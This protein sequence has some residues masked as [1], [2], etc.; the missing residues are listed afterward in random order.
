MASI[1]IRTRA[2]LPASGFI[3]SAILA[4]APALAQAPAD[5]R[6]QMHALMLACRGDYRR[7]CQGVQPG[8][9][10][11]LGC[12]ESHASALTA[13]C[14]AAVPHAEAL[15]QQRPGAAAPQ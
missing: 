12:L 8:G 6:Q 14:S 15:R 7:L 5:M 10:R 13:S 11:G 4:A 9:G 2:L 1:A 3:L